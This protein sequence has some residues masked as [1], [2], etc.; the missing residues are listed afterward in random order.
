MYTTKEQFQKFFT[1]QW[2]EILFKIHPPLNLEQ[3]KEAIIG[4][5]KLKSL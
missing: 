2:I 1:P 5:N 3:I 4:N